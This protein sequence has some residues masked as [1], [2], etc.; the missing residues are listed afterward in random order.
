[1]VL[2]GRTTKSEDF[3]LVFEREDADLLNFDITIFTAD[4]DADKDWTR[5]PQGILHCQRFLF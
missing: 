1:M 3:S 4:K 2:E 5:D